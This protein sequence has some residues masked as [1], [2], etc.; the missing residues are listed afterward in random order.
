MQLTNHDKINAEEERCGLVAA[1][2][3]LHLEQIDRITLGIDQPLE[4][5]G[6]AVFGLKIDHPKFLCYPVAMRGETMG[7]TSEV[8]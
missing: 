3:V 4:L 6:S 8:R 7:A 1:S 2:Q 5:S